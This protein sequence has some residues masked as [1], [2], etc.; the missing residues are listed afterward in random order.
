M[1]AKRREAENSDSECD[2]QGYD[3]SGSNRHSSAYKEREQDDLEEGAEISAHRAKASRNKH[4]SD[5][6]SSRGSSE[7]SE[8]D[9]ERFDNDKCDDT[10]MQ[11]ATTS[12]VKSDRE[13]QYRTPA[14]I[15][16]RNPQALEVTDEM[17][18]S[19]SE[20]DDFEEVVVKKPLKRRR[21]VQCLGN[22]SDD[23]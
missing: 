7:D 6:D 1:A 23:D 5:S 8:C 12:A 10:Q 22:D 20:S 16:K 3:S 11:T 2:E 13:Q 9:E 17:E 19:G 4:V 21:I 18:V 15:V 14:T